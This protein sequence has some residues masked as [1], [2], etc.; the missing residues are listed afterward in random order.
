MFYKIINSLI[1]FAREKTDLAINIYLACLI[2]I[3]LL[4]GVMSLGDGS[5]KTNQS[6]LVV[7]ESVEIEEELLQETID[8]IEIRE[9]NFSKVSEKAYQNIF[10]TKEKTMENSEN[11]EVTENL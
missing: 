4:I 9:E 5:I 8:Q 1:N 2:F 7:P 3:L 11:A 6:N 10:Q